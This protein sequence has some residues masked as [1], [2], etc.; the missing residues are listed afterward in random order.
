[1]SRLFAWIKSHKLVFLLLLIVGYLLYQRYY[2]Q[3]RYRSIT[4]P[5]SGMMAAPQ[6][7]QNSKL[8][9]GVPV[10]DYMRP[11]PVYDAPPTTGITDR[12]VIQE[13][14]LSL[15]V[16]NVRE[17]QD[18]IIQTAESLGG[19]MVNTNLNNPQDAPTAN[20]V[21]RI[22]STKLRAALDQFRGMAI[23]VVSENLSGQDVTDQYV[24]NEARL[25]TLENTKTKFEDIF[26]KAT[27]IEDILR[28]QQEILNIQSQID[29]V[30]GQQNYLEK[31]AQMSRVSVYLSTDELALPYAPSETWRPEVI[32]KQAVRSLVGNA[33]KLGTALIWLAVYSVIIIPL[34]L[35]FKF[36]KKRISL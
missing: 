19:Y 15:L 22:P 16:S 29:N 4:Y 23:K 21:V 8:G 36:I 1:M 7:V 33:R 28:V 9:F 24:D 30:K 10:S 13:S 20:L 18:Q 26:A 12:K 6:S 32:F 3:L 5:E 27:Q 2:P 11:E 17:V 31:N 34:A 14:N 35:I 25:Q